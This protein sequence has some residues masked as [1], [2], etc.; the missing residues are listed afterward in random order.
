M[1][2][3]ITILCHSLSISKLLHIVSRITNINFNCKQGD[4]SR[5]QANLPV[6]VDSLGFR[7]ASNLAPSAFLALLMESWKL[8][9]S[10]YPPICQLLAQWQG[11]GLV[12][13]EG[14]LACGHTPSYG[15]TSAKVLGP[16][17]SPITYLTP[18]WP[19]VP[20]SRLEH[21]YWVL[22]PVSQEHGLTHLL[23]RR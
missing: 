7:S 4:A 2:D 22:A 6:N 20:I 8:H 15:H 9:I 18:F 10:S 14:C 23:S 21:A 13:M 17:G 19:T 11:P 5:S 16:A 1:H 3:G 12:Y